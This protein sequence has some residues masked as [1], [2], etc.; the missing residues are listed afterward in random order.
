MKQY[1]PAKLIICKHDTKIKFSF[2]KNKQFNGL[3]V[4]NHFQ[5]VKTFL[6]KV[7]KCMFFRLFWRFFSET[8]PFLHFNIKNPVTSSIFCQSEPDHH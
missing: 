3:T 4:T 5:K 1:Q 2:Y 8:C 7:K 6:Q